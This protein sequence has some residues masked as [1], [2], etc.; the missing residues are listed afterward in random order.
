MPPH[1]PKGPFREALERRALPPHLRF[2]S[3]FPLGELPPSAERRSLSPALEP[4]ATHAPTDLA[5][6]VL[7]PLSGHSP[8]PVSPD[9]PFQ[10]QDHGSSAFPVSVLDA[11]DLEPLHGQKRR[12]RLSSHPVT[13]PWGSLIKG[14]CEPKKQ[15]LSDALCCMKAHTFA[16]RAC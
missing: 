7:A 1:R 12:D 14:D 16:S 6:M 4:A 10:V 15:T 3:K 9:Y 13:T 2:V 11:R 8:A 5:K